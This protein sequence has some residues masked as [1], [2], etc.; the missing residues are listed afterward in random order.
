MVIDRE[1]TLIIEQTI[2][3][4][5]K[6]WY[7]FLNKKELQE[8]EYLDLNT[9]KTSRKGMKIS[10]SL[11]SKLISLLLLF[12][13]SRFKFS[14]RQRNIFELVKREAAANI[15][16]KLQARKSSIQ[17]YKWIYKKSKEYQEPAH[18]VNA[19][20]NLFIHSGTI[21]RDLKEAKKYYDSSQHGLKLISQE[22]KVEWYYTD[23]IGYYTKKN[24]NEKALKEKAKAYIDELSLIEENER[25]ISFY[26]Y[27]YVIGILNFELNHKYF[28]LCEFLKKILEKFEIEYP[29]DFGQILL[30]KIYYS[31]Y[32]LRIRDYEK[33]FVI[34]SDGELLSRPK[35]V[36]WFRFKE[37]KVLLLLRQ[38]KSKEAIELYN[39]STSSRSFK[40][41][42]AD[43]IAR[44]NLLINYIEVYNLLINLDLKFN[45]RVGKLKF[46]KF[47]NSVPEYNKDKAGMNVS[48]IILQLVYYILVN[49]SAKIEERTEAIDKY[50]RR[51]MRTDPLFRSFTFMKMLLEVGKQNFHPVAVERHTQALLVKLRS[52]PFE[53]STH[54]SEMELI[55]YEIFWEAI[56]LHLKNRN[57]K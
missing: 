12:K 28:E 7:S 24:R 25:T 20:R 11:G 2:F 39:R 35:T 57:K 8:F 53:K 27:Y 46:G 14:L 52:V 47:L 4:G 29:H 21:K 41:L 13:P 17:I 42:R 37:L 36:S 54:P 19:S 1:L 49:A 15:L 45:T 3:H 50:M 56:M 30:L 10:S 34:I 51:Y 32:L 9:P 18:L 55:E 38:K 33:A 22:I 5:N 40:N 31:N 16:M 26:R 23:L 43:V 6:K 44:N 48:I